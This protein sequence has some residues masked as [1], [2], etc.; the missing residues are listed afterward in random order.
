MRGGR[1]KKEEEDDGKRE[2]AGGEKER[3]REETAGR[4]VIPF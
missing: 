2:G 3:A 4:E 1:I